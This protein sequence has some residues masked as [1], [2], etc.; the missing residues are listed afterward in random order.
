MDK[1]LPL[2]VVLLASL[3]VVARAAD[4]F[5][6]HPGLLHRQDDLARMKQATSAKEEPIYEGFE[7][8]RAHPASQSDYVSRGAAEEI[9]RNP[10]VNHA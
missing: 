7:K 9:G 2:L 1:L 5:F 3:A 10:S 8:F 4:S 6:I